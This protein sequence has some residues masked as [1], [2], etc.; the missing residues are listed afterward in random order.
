[1][2]SVSWAFNAIYCRIY[3][4]KQF[5]YL[6]FHLIKGGSRVIILNMKITFMLFYYEPE[7]PTINYLYRPVWEKL[8]KLGHEINIITPNP[9]RGI[10]LSEQQKY[11]KSSVEQN[12]ALTVYRVKC[13]TYKPKAFSK[14]NLLRRYISVSRRL[15]KKLESVPSDLVFVSTNPPLLYSY[16][17]TKYCA[18]KKIP[19]IYNVQDIYPD[20]I[21][22]KDTLAYNFFNRYQVK[23]LERATEV[24]T[25]SETMRNTL[26]KKGDFNNK[27]SVIY[28]FDISE[29]A[30][31]K[32]NNVP[33]FFDPMQFNVVYAGNIGYVQDLD[34]ILSAAKLLMHDPFISFHIFGEGSQAKRI[35]ERI[36]KENIVNTS[37]YPPHTVEE[38]ALLYKFADVNLISILPGIVMTALPLKTASCLAA[39]KPIVFIGLETFYHQEEWV[40][41][42]PNLHVVNYRNY[43]KLADVISKLVETK[44]MKQSQYPTFS[45][46][47]K[48]KNTDL[49]VSI[50]TK[51]L[52]SPKM[53]KRRK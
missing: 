31:I 15:A 22:K 25:I 29:V 30:K 47:D 42:V 32:H 6:F 53:A 37:Y 44:K 27:I 13:F 2:K 10:P 9:T 51:H 21:F 45:M 4:K 28:N 19:V 50:I 46:F 33:Y 7:D 11:K 40:E 52:K 36:R 43:Q 12:G 24:I 20:N 26:L 49:Y 14:F 8:I 17:V 48:E 18:K 34:V 5:F 35:A 39:K 3:A 23:T 1:M 38:S 16:L 41:T